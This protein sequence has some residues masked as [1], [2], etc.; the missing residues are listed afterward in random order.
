MGTF[1]TERPSDARLQGIEG[2]VLSLFHGRDA[3]GRGLNHHLRPRDGRQASQFRGT[4][5]PDLV[6][7]ARLGEPEPGAAAATFDLFPQ[8]RPRSRVQGR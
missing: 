2:L 4:R 3:F 8:T 6:E 5:Q 1:A 7:E